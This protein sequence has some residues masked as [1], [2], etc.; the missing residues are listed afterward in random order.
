ME[1][2][3]KCIGTEIEKKQQWKNLSVREKL[4]IAEVL[5]T[6]KKALKSNKDLLHLKNQLCV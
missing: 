3:V 5:A 6:I 1:I 2:S 4:L